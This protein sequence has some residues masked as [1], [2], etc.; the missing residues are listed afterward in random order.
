M[1]NNFI[2]VFDSDSTRLSQFGGAG[3]EE[4][5]LRYLGDDVADKD[6]LVYVCNE[7]NYR[8]QKFDSDGKFVAMID[9]ECRLMSHRSG[10][11]VT[12]DKLFGHRIVTEWN[13]GCVKVFVQ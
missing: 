1:R 5:K 12:D 11:C 10:I 2:H 8:I 6:G 9:D 13:T 4:G 7:M 3:S